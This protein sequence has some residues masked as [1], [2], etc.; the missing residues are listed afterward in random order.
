[1]RDFLNG[2]IGPFPD[3]VFDVVEKTVQDD[4]AAYRWQATGTFTGTPFQGVEPTG[5]RLDIEGIDVLIVRDGEIVENNAFADGMT[6]ARQL[7]LMPPEGSRPG[8]RD[9]ARVQHEDEGRREARRRAAWR[10]S[11]RASGSCAAASR[12]RR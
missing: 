1:M 8:A 12:A 5:A 9:E 7:G 10:T 11:P 2:L 4:R 3:L 6:V